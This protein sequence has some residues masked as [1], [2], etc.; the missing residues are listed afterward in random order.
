MGRQL[1]L[2]Q[3]K[4]FVPI[5]IGTHLNF[6]FAKTSFMRGSLSTHRRQEVGENRR[7]RDNPRITQRVRK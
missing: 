1:Q 4:R 7:E 3:H 6:C 2:T 5:A